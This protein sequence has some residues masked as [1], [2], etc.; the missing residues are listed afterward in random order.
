MIGSSDGW[1]YHQHAEW[2]FRHVQEHSTYLEQLFELQITRNE[3]I[4][5]FE[6]LAEGDIHPIKVFVSYEHALGV[7]DER[8][9]L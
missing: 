2:Y 6:Q 3:L 5:T 7:S 1:D 4:S 9:V 8:A